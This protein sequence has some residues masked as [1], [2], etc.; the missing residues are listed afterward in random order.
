M[1]PTLLSS[2]G[3]VLNDHGLLAQTLNPRKSCTVV[4]PLPRKMWQGC[5]QGCRCA[6]SLTTRRFDLPLLLITSPYMAQIRSAPPSPAT[7]I[8][9]TGACLSLPLS[10][11]NMSDNPAVQD[12]RGRTSSCT[13]ATPLPRFDTKGCSS[14]NTLTRFQAGGL[15]NMY[16][17]SMQRFEV[18]KMCTMNSL[19]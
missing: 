16:L 4:T 8:F 9:A 7:T 12:V 19:T 18:F 14:R 2:N 13:A 6:E 15:Q 1:S 5:R 3:L 17:E 10:S 11:Y